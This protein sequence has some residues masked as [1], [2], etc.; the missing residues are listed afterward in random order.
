MRADAPTAPEKWKTVSEKEHWARNVQPV[1]ALGNSVFGVCIPHTGQTIPK[2]LMCRSPQ[3]RNSPLAKCRPRN[4]GRYKIVT[5]GRTDHRL[6]AKQ[7]VT[8]KRPGKRIPT[9]IHE[10]RIIMLRLSTA[11][12][13]SPQRTSMSMSAVPQV[14]CE[15]MPAP[16]EVQH[17]SSGG[18]GK[19]QALWA[20]SPPS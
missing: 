15:T 20:S 14:S 4:A 2:S 18:G 19:S 16:A 12:A 9:I 3:F 6:R 1:K 5:A 7:Q 8:A 13:T 10:F 17:E 11:S